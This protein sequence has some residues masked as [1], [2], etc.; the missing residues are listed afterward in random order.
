MRCARH[1]RAAVVL[2]ICCALAAACSGTEA[3]PSLVTAQ[4]DTVDGVPRLL[5][6]ASGGADLAWRADTLAVIGDILGDDPDYQFDQVTPNALAGDEAGNLW[7]LDP[8]G[9]RVVGYR[10]DGRFIASH[11]RQGDGPGEINM[12]FALDAGPADTLWV[13][14]GMSRRLTGFPAAGGE[15]RI[16]S[17]DAGVVPAPPLVVGRDAMLSTLMYMFTPGRE[18]DE[19]DRRFVL[20]R[21]DR[22]GT[23]R[24]TLFS[25]PMPKQ[26]VVQIEAGSRRM[27][28]MATPQFAPVL[29][30]AAFADGTVAVVSDDRYSIRLL[31]ADGSERLR[32]EREGAPRAVTDADRIAVRER[33]RGQQPRMFGG[34]PS[35]AEE[36]RR[37]Q[38]EAMTFAATVPRIEQVAVDEQDRLW[39][40]ASADEPGGTP[41]IDLYDRDG[42]L[43]GSLTGMD[44][45]TAFLRGGLAAYLDK[46]ED[47]DVQQVT[48]V[49]LVEDAPRSR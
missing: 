30:W 15:P 12:A 17:F 3:A 49:R 40:R 7:L 37:R 45:P 19:A 10:T 4:R 28:M 22:D 16:I 14:E 6:P 13:L 5:Y 36:L 25:M 29:R 31:G 11:G 33:M 48:V 41:R 26:D 32:I 43:L 20:A 39:V 27:M 24:D 23:V 46:D 9:H 42:A 21:F 34:D 8:A 1:T 2:L 44:L 47:T 38:L 18:I 35:M